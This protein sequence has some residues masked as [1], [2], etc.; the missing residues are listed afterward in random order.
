VAAV[1]NPNL[2]AVV[3]IVGACDIL[4]NLRKLADR[5][6]SGEITPL[7]V[8]CI[9]G[10]QVMCFGPVNADKAAEGAIFDMTWGIH[11]LMATAN[12]ELTK[13]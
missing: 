11:Y 13:Q 5:L 9:A 7:H 10:S 1:E 3:P 6:E 2:R 12:K 4:A 8:T